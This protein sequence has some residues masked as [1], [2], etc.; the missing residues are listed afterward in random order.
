[1][2]NTYRAQSFHER[3]IIL[4]DL[5]GG[6]SALA[7][8]SNLSRRVIDKYKAG[9]SEPS[10]DRLLAMAR[11]AGVS[12]GWLVAG[13]G[14]MRPDEPTEAA[15][16]DFVLLP[17][18]DIQLSAGDG[19]FNDRAHA[20]GRVPFPLSFLRDLG[21][22]NA[23]ELAILKAKGDSMEPTVHD[24]NLLLIDQSDRG[25]RDGIY[26]FVEGDVAYVKRIRRTHDGVRIISDNSAYPP[27]TFPNERLD[28]LQVIGR[29]RWAARLV[30]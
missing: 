1:M 29:V 19:S 3:I 28:E 13:E 22:S 8:L 7:R 17:I 11:A 2:M 6:A 10:R 30:L 23:K 14:P 25:L 20:V 18:Y 9:E 26:A 24:G 5:V 4:T 16:G 12:I 21:H 15:G 27:W